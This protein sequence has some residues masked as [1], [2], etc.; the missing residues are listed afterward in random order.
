[1]SWSSQPQ[2]GLLIAVRGSR[3]VVFWSLQLNAIMRLFYLSLHLLVE[4]LFDFKKE[5]MRVYPA[6]PQSRPVESVLKG[7][8]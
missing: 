2:E 5:K 3:Y 8:P 1:M 6:A 4:G 7:K